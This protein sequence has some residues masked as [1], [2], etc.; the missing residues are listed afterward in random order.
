MRNAR[1][2]AYFPKP[3]D[4]WE[5]RSPEE[6]GMDAALL[7]EAVEYAKSHE[8]KDQPAEELLAE[9][10]KADA[11]PGDEVVGPVRGGAEMSG[12][13]V[14]QGYLVAEWGDT[15]K[16]QMSFSVT[17]SYLSAVTGLAVGSGL[18]ASVDDPVCG[19]VQEPEGLF[20]AGH[21]QKI[22]WRHLLQQ[23]SEWDGVLWGKP[24]WI[25]PQGEQEEGYEPKAP[26]SVFAYN[27]VRTNLL[28][29][30]LLHVFREPL[31]RVL[32]EGIMDP[33]GASTAWR[34]H[35]YENSWVTLDGLRMQ[36][37][38]GGGHWGGGMWASSRDHA[39]FGLLYLRRGR[40]E[41]KQLLPEWWIEETI[42]P[43]PV[44]P[45][46]GF[47]W[48]LNTGRRLYPSASESSFFAQGSGGNVVWVEPEHDLVTIVRHIAPED[49]F[50]DGF[51]KKI[52]AAA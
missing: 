23:T 38:S 19:Y 49:E 28:A 14:R 27:D 6:V 12:I 31:P 13:V 30:C 4:G 18:I 51:F 21:A 8:R 43:C 42:T 44:E 10:E 26:G 41:D 35:G 33:I 15:S 11:L 47:M 40:W 50:T 32:R 45:A 1:E 48:W 2:A 9:S 22:T 20:D 52:L 37:V 5:H 34:W 24:F 39:R 36:S 17:K 3:A 7:A 16:V 25:E 29:L 46:Y